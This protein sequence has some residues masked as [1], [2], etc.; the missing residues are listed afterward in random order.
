MSASVAS[1]GSRREQNQ[2]RF[3]QGNERLH[4]V[5]AEIGPETLEVRFLCECADDDCLGDVN[6]T[7]SAW[8][9][10]AARPNHYLLIAGHEHSEGEQV[11]GRVGEYEIARKP[12]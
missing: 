11:V 12:D 1:R 5:A 2:D 7:L 8:E 3:R 10:V 4:D 9:S 6:V